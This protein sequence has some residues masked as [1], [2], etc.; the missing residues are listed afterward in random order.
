MSLVS[1][2]CLSSWGFRLWRVLFA[3]YDDEGEEARAKEYEESV[4]TG[5][6]VDRFRVI[7]IIALRIIV[8]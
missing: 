8:I 1:F 2:S 5:V 4:E 3:G 7:V 6:D